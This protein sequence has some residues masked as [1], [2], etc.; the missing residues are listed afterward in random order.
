MAPRPHPAA[1][2][3]YKGDRTLRQEVKANLLPLLLPFLNWKKGDTKGA[4][5]GR[6]GSH[7]LAGSVYHLCSPLPYGLRA[8][9]SWG[10]HGMGSADNLKV[11]VLV[12]GNPPE[13][14]ISSLY[15]HESFFLTGDTATWF[16]T[17]PEVLHTLPRCSVGLFCF[18]LNTSILWQFLLNSTISSWREL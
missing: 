7:M 15:P 8:L 5:M 3:H 11:D 13:V 4:K 10:T 1:H 12:G 14:L 18:L 9:H 6:K 16:R 2:P 17:T